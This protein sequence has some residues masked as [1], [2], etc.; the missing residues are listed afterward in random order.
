MP[1]TGNKGEWS[2]IYV[3]L[4]LLGTGVLKAGD[5]Q[6]NE[7]TSL[8]YPIIT[9]LRTETDRPVNYQVRMPNVVVEHA[10]GRRIL[11]L[12]ANEFL[13]QS[14]RL[15]EAI[16]SGHGALFQ[17][18]GAFSIP[19]TEAFMH[20]IQCNELKAPNTDK[21]DIRI[22]LHDHRT[23]LNAEMGFSIKSHLGGD[24]TLLNAAKTTNVTYSIIGVDYTDADIQRINAIHD[25]AKLLKRY[26]TIVQDGGKFV[27]DR[28]DSPI[29]QNNL[30]MLDCCMPMLVANLLTLR[31][32]TREKRI[33]RLTEI[34]AD[35]N[36]LQLKADNI[37]EIYTYKL[38]HLLASVALGMMPGT[39]WNGHYDVNGGYI[40]VKATG[41]VLCYHFYD[42]NRFE[43][44]LFR[45]AY[46]EAASTTRHDYGT[47]FS[48][49]SGHLHFKLNLQ[50]RLTP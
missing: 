30:L 38:K 7:I 4:R 15:L 19:E 16:S 31:L 48:D 39:L 29:F 2:E 42:R 22:V 34:M 45:H 37:Q 27:F 26:E 6:L 24:S 5:E 40:V 8:F 44:Y 23:K 13:H 10:D 43:D 18:K 1:I 14:E 32:Q 3:L 50:L 33:D 35:C 25:N 12:P 28:M 36:P 17:R 20:S 41:E 21:T 47:L 46:L 9:I 11:C 49:P